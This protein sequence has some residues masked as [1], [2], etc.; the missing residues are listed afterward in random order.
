MIRSLKYSKGVVKKS[1]YSFSVGD[2]IW[3]DV[4]DPDINELKKISKLTGVYVNDMQRSLDIDALPRVTNRKV[5]SMVVLRALSQRRK[6]APF[7]L[8]INNKFIVTVHKKKVF[9]ID[10]LFALLS[11][12]E[13]KEL[14]SNGLTYIFFRIASY[15]NKRFHSELDKLEDE[16]DKLED[17]ILDG[18][19]DNPS[20]IY[21][22]KAVVMVIRRALISNR[23]LVDLISGGYSKHINSKNQNWLS[24]L[25]IETE[26]VVSVTELLR[27]RLTGAMEMYMSSISNKLNDIM[28]GFTVVASLL[29]LPMLVSGIWGMN[30]AKI[31]FF[32]N[33]YGFYIPLLIMLVSVILMSFWFKS[34]K[35]T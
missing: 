17:D 21:D 10:D 23:N 8:F 30:F 15:V 13:G 3:I 22:K 5:Y 29:L 32:D 6:Y 14:F 28:R 20:Q 7:G 12:K 19:I 24:E 35:W 4:S 31:P 34:K 11:E 33:P 9:A 25:K 27:E 16:I 2:R 26:Q 18:K 1:S